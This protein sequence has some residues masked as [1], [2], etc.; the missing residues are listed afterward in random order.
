MRLLH[1]SRSQ[2]ECKG[3]ERAQQ[4]ASPSGTFMADMMTPFVIYMLIL[5]FCQAS[6]KLLQRI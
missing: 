5:P 2:S 3:G 1:A 6:R 4:K